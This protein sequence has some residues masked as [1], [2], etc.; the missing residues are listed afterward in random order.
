M[1]NSCPKH[2]CNVV[3][4]INSHVRINRNI[5]YGSFHL[6]LEDVLA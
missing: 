3:V 6:F 1:K 4:I 2:Q 5:N